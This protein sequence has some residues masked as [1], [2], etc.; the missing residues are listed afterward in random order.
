MDT[1]PDDSLPRPTRLAASPADDIVQM[2]DVDL[3]DWIYAGRGRVIFSLY[4]GV[5]EVIDVVYD[6]HQ[7]K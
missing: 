6:P 2:P 4:E 3:R 7:K 1:E 5:L